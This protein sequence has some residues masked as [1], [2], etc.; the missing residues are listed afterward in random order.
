MADFRA[1]IQGELKT[2]KINEQIKGI[3][4][5]GLTFRNA[6]ISPQALNSIQAA[7]DN[8]Q[9]RLNIDG[10]NIGNINRQLQNAGTNAGRQFNDAFQRTI[11]QDSATRVRNML[12]YYS[13]P[14]SVIN[15]TIHNVQRLGIELDRIRGVERRHDT[16]DISVEGVDSIG[17]AI[18]AVQRF[19]AVTGEFAGEGRV[20]ITQTF[21]DIT[22]AV[23]NVQNSLSN[24]TIARSLSDIEVQYKKLSTSERRLL[25]NFDVDIERLQQSMYNMSQMDGADL[26]SEFDNFDN[27]AASLR[28]S[29]KIVQNE[30]QQFSNEFST[31]KN[32]AND[33][34]KL[35]IKIAKLDMNDDAEEIAELTS[36]LNK[37]CATYDNLF[38]LMNGRLNSSQL[39]E[40]S[41]IESHTRDSVASISASKIDDN[42]IAATTE[43]FKKL[44]DVAKKI[45]NLEFKIAG[46]DAT[47]NTNEI[48]ALE[49]QLEELD[50]EYADL[51]GNLSRE[52]PS[53]QQE[54]LQS[55]FDETTQKIDVLKGKLADARSNFENSIKFKIDTNSVDLSISK[56]EAQYKKLGATGHTSLAAVKKDLET[57]R[58]L[59]ATMTS[60]SGDELIATY[61]QY[62]LV[63]QRVKNTLGKVAVEGEK[64][65]SALDVQTF[66]N[67][68]DRW[69][70]KNS[71]AAKKFGGE[72]ENIRA[73]LKE[74]AASGQLTESALKELNAELKSV[75]Q[76]AE[77]A[78][79]KGR[80]LAATF[81]KA[82]DSIK[83]YISV[84]TI[85]YKG[86]EAAKQMAQNVYDIDTAMTNLY[87]VTDETAARYERFLR[88]SAKSAKDLGRTISSVVEQTATWAKL[89]YTLNQAEGLAKL[90]AVYANVA[91][92]DDATAVSDMVT[93]MKAF[94]IEAKNAVT[95]IDPLNELGKHIA[96]DNYIG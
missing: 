27:L 48:I 79:L 77:A 30:T 16:I 56:V 43:E 40:L 89:G 20:S 72:I 19:N 61:Q 44:Y 37:L 78:G 35:E 95:V 92:V 62:E 32:T 31:L 28:N 75:D 4:N 69:L 71:K 49:R 70:E 51:V 55:V 57:L 26:L 45:Q 25:P 87:K 6:T 15:K 42:N 90:S 96:H 58:S 46:L 29:L 63:L 54:K 14:E 7:L 39:S 34:G 86:I 3:E 82:F 91:E 8:H 12:S 13:M 60:Q 67:K 21:R 10:V 59:E 94:N 17:N 80:S 36:H 23:A 38:G 53:G 65:A 11:G 74:M 18:V 24:G 88:D 47:K 83:N 2:T 33:I 68:L 76:R 85:V 81:S 84:S 41:E 5:T 66:N 22:T 64:M 93:A 9:F 52:L 50:I 1:L 73:R